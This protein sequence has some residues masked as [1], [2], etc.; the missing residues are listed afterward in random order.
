[1]RALLPSSHAPDDAHLTMDR[2]LRTIRLRLALA[3]DDGPAV[4]F[5][6]DRSRDSEDCHPTEQRGPQVCARGTRHPSIRV[7]FSQLWPGPPVAPPAPRNCGPRCP[8]GARCALGPFRVRSRSQRDRR[9]RGRDI[10]SVRLFFRRPSRLLA[11]RGVAW[12]PT[13]APC[14]PG[15]PNR[16]PSRRASTDRT[17]APSGLARSD[18]APAG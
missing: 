2:T 3:F 12:G 8:H 13:A 11:C 10:H 6:I 18:G 7:P 15:G 16:D 14:W 4:P 9:S 1:M 17:E 5:A